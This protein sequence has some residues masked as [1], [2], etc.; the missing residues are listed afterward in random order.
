V[1]EELF[2]NR[3]VVELRDDALHEERK[4]KGN[5]FESAKLL[6]TGRGHHP[7][8]C[9]AIRWMM[10]RPSQAQRCCIPFFL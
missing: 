3:L 5:D 2:P 10:L 8:A 1:G 7:A 4:K 9:K 6:I